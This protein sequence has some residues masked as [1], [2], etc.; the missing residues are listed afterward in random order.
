MKTLLTT[1]ALFSS[2]AL[3]ESTTLRVEGMHCAGC[4]K[5]LQMQVCEDKALKETFE[6][7]TVKLVDTKN[8]V[9]QIKISTKNDSK[10]DMKA[11]MSSIDAS[12]EAYKV[13]VEKK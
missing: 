3:A 8:R 13:S 6:T 2:V 12:G 1:M 7:C 11:I 10:I 5:V 4:T 9:G